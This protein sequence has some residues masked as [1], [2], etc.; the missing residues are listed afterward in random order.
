VVK[1]ITKRKWGRAWEAIGL[2]ALLDGFERK[3]GRPP[4]G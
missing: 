4:V 1:E 2:F 3:L